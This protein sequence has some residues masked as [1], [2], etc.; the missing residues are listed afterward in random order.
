MHKDTC[1]DEKCKTWNGMRLWHVAYCAWYSHD[2]AGH[3]IRA[4]LWG[5]YAD[6]IV[7]WA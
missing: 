6:R 3:R 1:L 4:A 5:W 7:R 2:R